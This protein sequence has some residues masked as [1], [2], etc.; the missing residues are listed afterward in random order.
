MKFQFLVS[1]MNKSESQVLDIVQANHLVPSATVINQ[2]KGDCY[3]YEKD[4]VRIYS[5]NERGLSRSR[6]RALERSDADICLICDDDIMYKKDV[7]LDITKAFEE[8]PAYDIIAFFVKKDDV[9]ALNQKEEIHEISFMQSLSLMS[10]QIAFKRKAIIENNIR[11][12]EL[13]GAGSG[14]Y[15]CGEENIFLSD[16]LR[17]GLKI[18][19]IPIEIAALTESESTWFKGYDEIYFKTK[20]A[21]FYRMSKLLSIPLIGAFALLKYNMYKKDM[22]FIKAFIA[23]F[24]GLIEYKGIAKNGKK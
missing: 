10:V 12:D 6:N 14:Q 24:K 20:G 13:F 7:Y 19:Y 8:N 5:Y 15:I 23:M 2:T 21:V 3:D 4:G 16:C 17:K 11:F 1:T 22:S 18:L 9:Y